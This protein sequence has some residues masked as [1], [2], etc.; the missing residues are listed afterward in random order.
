MSWWKIFGVLLIAVTAHP[1]V[2]RVATKMMLE[3]RVSY[4]L[5]L[6]I[7]AIEYTVAGGVF[8]LLRLLGGP[9]A[10]YAFAAI[11]FVF[12]G[13]TLIGR[14]LSLGSSEPLGIGNGVLIQFMQVP[15]VV[16]LLILGSFLIDP[17]R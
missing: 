13:A 1:L 5:A 2:L 15:L 8:G 11:A 7:V 9:T 12:V 6:K 16:P 14:W 17:T 10:A 4:A 3:A